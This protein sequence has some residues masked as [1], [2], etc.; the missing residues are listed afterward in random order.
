M[1]CIGTRCE[2]Q[3]LEK[4]AEQMWHGDLECSQAWIKV[5]YFLSRSFVGV[6][7]CFLELPII[8]TSVLKGR[9]RVL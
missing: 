4:R 1:V 9:K 3:L 2:A 5:G 7:F 6:C 8:H